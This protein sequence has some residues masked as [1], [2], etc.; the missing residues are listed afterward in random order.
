MPRL[1]LLECCVTF[2]FGR[3]PVQ[4]FPVV[5]ENLAHH[6]RSRKGDANTEVPLATGSLRFYQVVLMTKFHSRASRY[7]FAGSA[8]IPDKK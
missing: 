7:S 3:L 4:A 2:L 1:H 8:S 6:V 5:A